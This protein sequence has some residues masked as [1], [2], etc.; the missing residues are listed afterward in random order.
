VLVGM[1]KNLSH[2]P[3]EPEV[4]FTAAPLQVTSV[5]PDNGSAGQLVAV[6]G[7]SFELGAGGAIPTVQFVDRLGVATQATAYFRSQQLLAVIV[8]ALSPGRYAVTVTN[9]S[10]SPGVT[11]SSAFTVE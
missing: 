6:V 9:P 11:L 4:G 2:T 1:S 5:A 8:P 10:G 7:Q 3:V